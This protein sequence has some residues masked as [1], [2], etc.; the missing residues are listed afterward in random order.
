MSQT[1]PHLDADPRWDALFEAQHQLFIAAKHA[2]QA[3]TLHGKGEYTG[4]HDRFTL[5]ALTEAAKAL[6]YRLVK[7]GQPDLTGL[8]QASRIEPGDVVNGSFVVGD[9][10]HG[11]LDHQIRLR[12]PDESATM[13]VKD[14]DYL[15]V[16]REVRS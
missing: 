1:T 7:E 3:M 12:T 5:E 14:T 15:L 8:V 2:L 4:S 11:S 13:F 9:V 6:G 16:Q 10:S